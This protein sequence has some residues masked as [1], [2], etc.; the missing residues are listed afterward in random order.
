MVRFSKSS[1]LAIA[2]IFSRSS[3]S[4]MTTLGGCIAPIGSPSSDPEE[5]P[6]AHASRS[7][8]VTTG[9]AAAGL[10]AAFSKSA[11]LAAHPPSSSVTMAVTIS[12]TFAL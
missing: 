2:S 11:L 1:L 6:P 5:T 7:P 8:I 10:A 4:V 3:G 9:A 12:L